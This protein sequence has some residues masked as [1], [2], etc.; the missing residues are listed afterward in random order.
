MLKTGSSASWIEGNGKRLWR[1]PK[2]SAIKG[3]SA[4]EEEEEEEKEEEE[5]GGGGEEEEEECR[6]FIIYWSSSM[7]LDH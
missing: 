3:S 2:L 1:R 5:G 6:I 7:F 4:P